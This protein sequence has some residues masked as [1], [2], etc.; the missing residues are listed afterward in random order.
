MQISR[1]MYALEVSTRVIHVK[2]HVSEISVIIYTHYDFSANNSPR[3][4]AN[5]HLV[6]SFA[7]LVHSWEPKKPKMQMQI[8]MLEVV[9]LCVQVLERRRRTPRKALRPRRK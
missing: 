3:H 8:R 4:S 5:K 9:M 7:V 1:E 2:R 6:K